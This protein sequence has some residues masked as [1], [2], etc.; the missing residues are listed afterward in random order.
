MTERK[1]AV[2]SAF[3]KDG[4][5][6]NL[7]GVV[8]DAG[9]IGVEARQALA[10][11][12][13]F[14]ETVFVEALGPASF[15]LRYFTPTVEGDLCGHAT[16]ATFG[17]MLAQKRAEPGRVT[18]ETRVGELA[19]ELRAD[20]L[21]FMDQPLPVFGAELEPGPVS[22]VLGGAKVLDARLVST[23]LFDLL[24]E[25][26]T[27]EALLALKPDLPAI[28]K[29]TAAHGASS[30]HAFVRAQG[31]VTAY[32]RDFAPA[33]GIDEDTATG[34]ASG[35]LSCH[36][37]DRGDARTELR[38]IQG[39]TVGPGSEILARLDVEGKTIKRVRVGGRARL[40]RWADGGV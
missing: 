12:L 10:A 32:C 35:A 7:A 22:A 36:L 38:F 21:V 4:A 26:E 20:G 8:L 25:L 13:G 30:L 31:G 24:A 5:G 34:T 27:H 18:I 37:F 28:A 17:H 19:V 23:G 15:K 39:E 3:T 29:M 33:V 6:G 14:A 2:V 1:V 11:K 9:G 40:E 16:I